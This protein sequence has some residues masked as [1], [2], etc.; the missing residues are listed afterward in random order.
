MGELSKDMIGACADLA[1]LIWS[2]CHPGTARL[3]VAAVADGM[4]TGNAAQ[5]APA[6]CSS[7]EVVREPQLGGYARFLRKW[8]AFE[9]QDAA[10]EAL[11]RGGTVSVAEAQMAQQSSILTSQ[12][13]L[14]QFARRAATLTTAIVEYRRDL[15][16]ARKLSRPRRAS[17]HMPTCPDTHCRLPSAWANLCLGYPLLGLPS[18]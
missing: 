17:L 10:L 3:L 5:S 9:M 2:P 11:W 8:S 14:A 15:A 1:E 4:V 7:E 12:L 18:A 13:A 16:R 6:I